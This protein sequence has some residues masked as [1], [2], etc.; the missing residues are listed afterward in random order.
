MKPIKK[1]LLVVLILPILLVV[2]SLFLPSRYRVER[3]VLCKGRPE[4]VFAQINTLKNWAD[5]SAWTVKRFPDMVTTYAGPDSGPGA[6]MTWDGKS[7]GNGTLKIA[8]SD[9]AAG[10]T[11]DLAFEQGRYISKGR[12]QL[13]AAAES[14]TVVW[15]NEGELGGNP[16]SRFFGLLMDK[17]MGP[18]MAAGLA[19]LQKLAEAK[20]PA[21]PQAT[22]SR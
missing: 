2:V 18:D 1:V 4:V 16:V 21:E 9:P 22:P 11:Y 19:N 15:V 14:V 3:R 5:W 8:S 20:P 17:M 6:S 12:I 13:E 7:S 10:I